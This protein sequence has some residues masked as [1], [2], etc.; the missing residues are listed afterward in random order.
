MSVDGNL[1]VCKQHIL[2]EVN[3]KFK[4]K[5]HESVSKENYQ[6]CSSG[7]YIVQFV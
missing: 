6:W 7:T 5:S 4:E 1:T 3:K 2:G